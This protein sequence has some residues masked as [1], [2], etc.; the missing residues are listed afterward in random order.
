MFKKIRHWFNGDGLNHL[1]PTLTGISYVQ[2]PV[3]T[4][5]ETAL[6]ASHPATAIFITSFLTGFDSSPV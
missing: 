2:A 4:T 5:T 1:I 6:T 3:S